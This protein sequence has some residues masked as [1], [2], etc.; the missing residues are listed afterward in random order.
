MEEARMTKTTRDYLSVPK[1][2][3]GTPFGPMEVWSCGVCTVKVRRAGAGAFDGAEEAPCRNLSFATDSSGRETPGTETITV[4]RVNFRA[5]LDLF[6]VRPG[7]WELRPGDYGMLTRPYTDSGADASFAAREK[8]RSTLTGIAAAYAETD[9]GKALLRE[10]DRVRLNNDAFR[11][12]EK[13][14]DAR[15]ELEE[16]ESALRSIEKAEEVP[17]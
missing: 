17:A 16:M 6:E 12:E 13:I 5:R 10:G 15:A 8:F 9:D 1:A 14:R 7:T 3:I 11:L 4:N 2:K